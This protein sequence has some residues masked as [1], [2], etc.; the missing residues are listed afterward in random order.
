MATVC[1]QQHTKQASEQL[2][3]VPVPVHRKQENIKPTPVLNN[4]AQ[5][6][7]PNQSLPNNSDQWPA[8]Q[9]I[10]HSVSY[11]TM[12]ATYPA[13]SLCC[14]WLPVQQQTNAHA[15]LQTLRASFHPAQH[16]TQPRYLR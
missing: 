11:Y 8:R 2:P 6:A 9:N 16:T 1:H 12:M 15:T 3:H 5:T 10:T 7:G 14:W 4:A 13:S